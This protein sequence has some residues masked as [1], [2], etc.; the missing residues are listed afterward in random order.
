MSGGG[1][2]GTHSEETKKL[3]SAFNKGNKYA[4]GAKRTEETKRKLSK[5]AK[6]R[7]PISEATRQK[8]SESSK[9]RTHT[10]ETK[11]RLSEA[12]I[13][14]KYPLGCKR[15][16]ETLKKMSHPIKIDDIEYFSYKEAGKANGKGKS[17]FGEIVHGRR[18][19]T[20]N[21]KIEI[22]KDNKWTLLRENENE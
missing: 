19:N 13:G 22:L 4:F 1:S 14:N 17:Y 20:H 10:E 9:G 11:R 12:K 5:S 3:I 7:P 21:Y 16:V 8:L 2:K 18:K 6:K 15:S